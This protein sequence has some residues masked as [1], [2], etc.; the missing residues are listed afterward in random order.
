LTI[1]QGQRVS[2]SALVRIRIRTTGCAS[3]QRALAMDIIKTPWY[4]EVEVRQPNKIYQGGP[5][6][7]REGHK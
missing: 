7:E 5:S 4:I 3:G 6:H 2:F 1:T